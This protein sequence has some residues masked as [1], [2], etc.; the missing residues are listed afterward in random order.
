MYFKK[1]VVKKKYKVQVFVVCPVETHF[2]ILAM[3]LSLSISIYVTV[4]ENSFKCL[5][6]INMLNFDIL[7]FRSIYFEEEVKGQMWHD[8]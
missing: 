8:L 1:F 5:N 7:T 6:V 4:Q 3:T 2:N